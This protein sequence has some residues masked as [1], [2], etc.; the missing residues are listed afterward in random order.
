MQCDSTASVV[1]PYFFFLVDQSPLSENKSD[2][3]SC[4][5]GR[6][7]DGDMER[8]VAYD[9]DEGDDI[10]NSDIPVEFGPLIYAAS[11]TRD[12]QKAVRKKNNSMYDPPQNLKFII[13]SEQTEVNLP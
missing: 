2:S 3:T 1:F 7:S 10:D 9:I 5:K 12:S 11:C 13:Q 4:F 8:H 6:I